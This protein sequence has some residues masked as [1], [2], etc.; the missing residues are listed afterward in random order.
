MENHVSLLHIDIQSFMNVN[1][2]IS[3]CFNVITAGFY[4]PFHLISFFLQNSGNYV[5]K[6]CELFNIRK[7]RELLNVRKFRELIY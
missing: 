6:F 2:H 3:I 4:M 1:D 7:F 5:V